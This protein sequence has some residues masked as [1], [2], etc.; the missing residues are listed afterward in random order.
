ML[1]LLS[2]QLCDEKVPRRVMMH[3]VSLRTITQQQTVSSTEPVSQFEIL[4][5]H[6]TKTQGLGLQNACKAICQLLIEVRLEFQ[7]GRPGERYRGGF[8]TFQRQQEHTN[9]NEGG[10][11][12]TQMSF[13]IF[14]TLLHSFCRT[15]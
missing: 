15:W 4:R 11:R 8:F 7:I 9:N 5:T 10:G 13:S 2:S 1:R 12:T 14:F 3:T 6:Q